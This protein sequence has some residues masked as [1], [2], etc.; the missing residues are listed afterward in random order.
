M[1]DLT[2][3]DFL[4]GAAAIAAA[5]ALPGPVAAIDD[6]ITDDDLRAEAVRV[7]AEVEDYSDRRYLSARSSSGCGGSKRR[8]P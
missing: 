5:T 6:Q 4:T 8:G 2:R 3:R 1:D 7:C